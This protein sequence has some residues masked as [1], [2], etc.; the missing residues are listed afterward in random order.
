MEDE[1]GVTCSTHR[2]DSKCI[3]YFA[4]KTWKEETTWKTQV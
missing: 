1:M 2:S 4:W 3:Q